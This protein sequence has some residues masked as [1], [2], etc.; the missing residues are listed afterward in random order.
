MG[1]EGSKAFQ[2][3]W[4][5]IKK[6]GWPPVLAIGLKLWE[7]TRLGNGRTQRW[8]GRRSWREKE[9]RY[10]IW[11]WRPRHADSIQFY[12][13]LPRINSPFMQSPEPPS[14]YLQ[15]RFQHPSKHNAECDG[16][17]TDYLYGRTPGTIFTWHVENHHLYS[18]N[19]QIDGADKVWYIVPPYFINN[20][21]R[22][23]G[24]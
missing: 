4:E 9:A 12:L 23:K 17:H 19:Y 21:L 13:K 3:D 8:C 10:S 7:I 22:Q 15:L 14:E 16:L 6:I 24:R 18:T 2:L 11:R 5:G 20:L 1:I